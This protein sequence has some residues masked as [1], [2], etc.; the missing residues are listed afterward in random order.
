MVW[1]KESEMIQRKFTN[2]YLSGSLGSCFGYEIHDSDL[3]ISNT[4][5]HNL[6]PQTEVL[7][8]NISNPY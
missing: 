4:L 8:L 7:N 6:N 1:R 5:L 3:N 2:R